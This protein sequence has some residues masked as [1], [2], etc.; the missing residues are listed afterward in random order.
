MCRHVA[1]LRQAVAAYAAGFDAGLLTCDDAARAAARAF[2]VATM[3]S[4][5]AAWSRASR[6][7]AAERTEA[8]KDAA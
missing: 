7:S 8:S 5:A 4:M 2:T 1:E 6:A 3:A